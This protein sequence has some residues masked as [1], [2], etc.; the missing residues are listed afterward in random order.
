MT[1]FRRGLWM[2]S[3]R[4]EAWSVSRNGELAGYISSTADGQTV[5]EL[6]MADEAMI[7]PAIKAWM[8]YKGAKLLHINAAPYDVLLGRLLA[9]ICEG[10]SLN[11]SIMLRV[12]KPETVLPAYMK[13]KNAVAPLSPGRVVLGWEGVGA[14]EFSV[15]GEEISVRMSDEEPLDWLSQID[16]HQLLF[17]YNRYAAP[18]TAASIPENWFPLPVHIPEPDSF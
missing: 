12:L 17:G 4:R 16:F 8:E 11:P 18:K 9:P 13:L 5:G 2:N 7:L 15:S 10:F 1:A 3:S 6:I 14:L